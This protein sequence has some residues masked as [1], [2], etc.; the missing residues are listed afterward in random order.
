MTSLRLDKWLWFA[1]L[2]KTRSLA[3]KLCSGGRVSVG[4][5]VVV[6]PGH[7]VRRGDV[8]TVEQGRIV[9]CVTVLALGDRRG[10]AAEARLL[11][12]EPEPPRARRDLDRAAWLPLLE[13]SASDAGSGRLTK[14]G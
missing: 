6:K 12:A 8:V 7:L 3:A 14:D 11:Y 2:A 13:E 10:P 4:G 5:A 1:R 9:R